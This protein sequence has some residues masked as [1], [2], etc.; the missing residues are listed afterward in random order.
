M[1]IEDKTCPA[2]SIDLTETIIAAEISTTLHCDL[3]PI[4]ISIISVVT[5]IG[6]TII[7][8]RIFASA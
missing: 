3:M 6:W 1:V 5:M 4:I 7:A 8:F 2:F